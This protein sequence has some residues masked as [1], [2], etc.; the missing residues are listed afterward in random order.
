MTTEYI[1]FPSD[2]TKLLSQKL[3][4]T[5]VNA[6][7]EAL[8]ENPQVALR[9]NI[10]KKRPDDLLVD[11]SPVAWCTTG[12][13]LPYRPCFSHLPLWHSGSF[14][15]QD[16]STMLL[17]QAVK[18]IQKQ[19]NPKTVL[20][21]C[22]APGGKT[23]H[24]LSL[25]PQ[26]CLVV[27]NEIHPQRNFLLQ[28]NCCKWGQNNIIITRSAPE[29]FSSVKHLFDVLLIDAPCSGEGMFRKEEQA[30]NHWS[31]ENVRQSAERQREI[32]TDAWHSLKSGGYLIYST[33]TFNRQ[34]N[35]D[36]VAWICRNF[37]AQTV[38]IP[39]SPSWN[40]D[41]SEYGYQC[42][43][44]KVK[45]EGFF[46]ALI[47][48]TGGKPV[49]IPQ[50]HQKSRISVASSDVIAK[51]LTQK[52]DI[53]TLENHFF[54]LSPQFS[55][56]VAPLSVLDITQIGTPISSEA[57]KKDIIP[58]TALS[59]SDIINIAAFETLELSLEKSLEYLHFPSLQNLKLGTDKY[60]IATYLQQPLGF[61][62]NTGKYYN[63]LYPK[64]WRL[65]AMPKS[66]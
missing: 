33:C 42:Y 39:V 43:P 29:R 56:Y 6:L 19:E 16:A 5:E 59:L 3:P 15:V 37:D 48:K 63:S 4:T 17:E 12:Y 61:L 55:N 36:M 2:F 34:E 22:A 1:P 27:A 28:E 52:M 18:E 60:V 50:K 45:G 20:D 30:I 65:R 62:K 23:T 10:N 11:A 35:E 49:T 25:L 64:Y 58:H 41:V 32:I 24:L 51:W 47:Q 46:M 66:K 53:Y 38:E 13:Q 8:R 21:L 26:D 57:F 54:V 31:L 44:H 14:Y 40:I 9:C 7:L